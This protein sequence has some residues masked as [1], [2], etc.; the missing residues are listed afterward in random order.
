MFSESSNHLTLKCE[1]MKPQ[2]K[3]TAFE[4][5]IYRQEGL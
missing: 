4:E 2:D 5:F 1:N 3:R